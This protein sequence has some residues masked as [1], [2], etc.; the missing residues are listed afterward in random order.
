MHKSSAHHPQKHRRKGWMSDAEIITIPVLFHS[1]TFRNFKHCYLFF[2]KEKL[3]E[4]FS[5]LHSYT[6]FLERITRVATPYY[7]FSNLL[8]TC[9]CMGITFIDSTHILVCENKRQYS[10]KVFQRLCTEKEKYNGLVLW[11][12]ASFVVQ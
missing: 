10:N 3:K 8:I 7:P 2:V 6:H 9:E 12:Q 1:N 11:F 4:N 5:A